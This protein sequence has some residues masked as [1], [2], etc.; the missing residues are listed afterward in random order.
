MNSTKIIPGTPLKN[1][2]SKYPQIFKFWNIPRI[3]LFF[4]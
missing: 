3:F 2:F 4:F 1:T